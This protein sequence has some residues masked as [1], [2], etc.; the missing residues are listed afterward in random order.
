[1]SFAKLTYWHVLPQTNS[2]HSDSVVGQTGGVNVVPNS[3]MSVVAAARLLG[4]P[5]AAIR[6]MRDA[7]V[8]ATIT[9]RSGRFL[10]ASSVHNAAADRSRMRDGHA[11]LNAALVESGLYEG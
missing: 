9:V 11:A 2:S 10:L 1:M 4:V 7:G 3:T 8:L 5:R 6:R